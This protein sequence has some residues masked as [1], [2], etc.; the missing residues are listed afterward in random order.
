MSH[1]KS[2]IKGKTTSFRYKKKKLSSPTASCHVCREINSRS[3]GVGSYLKISTSFTVSQAAFLDTECQINLPLKAGL[4]MSLSWSEDS[5]I[6]LKASWLAPLL[7]HYMSEKEQIIKPPA[8]PNFWKKERKKKK[9][10]WKLQGN[11]LITCRWLFV[12]IYH[13]F[14]LMVIVEVCTLV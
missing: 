9:K 8:P 4:N 3:S 10:P 13:Y 2:A 12:V 11:G 7:K 14:R 6:Y 5:R 1:V